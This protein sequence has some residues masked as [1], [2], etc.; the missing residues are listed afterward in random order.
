MNKL[1]LS[2]IALAVLTTA[3]V[4]SADYVYTAIWAPGPGAYAVTPALDFAIQ[5]NAGDT[6]VATVTYFADLPLDMGLRI[7]APGQSCTI[8]DPANPPGTD[9]PCLSGQTVN[10]C[11]ATNPDP[12]ATATEGTITRTLVATT[13]GQHKISVSSELNAASRIFLTL[14]IDVNG[15]TPAVVGPTATNYANR[16]VVCKPLP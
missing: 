4:V 5:A 14:S 12:I 10:T 13:S 9:V 3:P 2:A 6:I 7:L 16:G 11:P 1:A 15:G 8:F